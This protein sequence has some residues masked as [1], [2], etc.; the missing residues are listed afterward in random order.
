MKKVLIRFL[1]LGTA[2]VLFFSIVRE[3]RVEATAA[4]IRA[5]AEIVEPVEG[6]PENTMNGT[7][8]GMMISGIVMIVIVMS[9]LTRVEK[10]KKKYVGSNLS[11]S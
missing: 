9:F 8:A 6:V 5:E 11:M 3:S 2:F 4:T 1:L 7:A 10:K